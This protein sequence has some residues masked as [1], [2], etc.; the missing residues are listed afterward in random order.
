MVPELQSVADMK[1]TK[2][3]ILTT[4]LPIALTALG[5]CSSVGKSKSGDQIAAQGP[6]VLDARTNPGTF[7]LNSAY[8]PTQPAEILAEVK[9]FSSNIKDVRLRF[10]HVPLEIP[11]KHVEGSTW[12]AQ[13]SP[14]QLKSLAVGGQTMNYQVNVIARSADG[15]VATS[16]EPLKVAVSAPDLSQ[17]KG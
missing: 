8:Q 1:T 11:M 14:N 4:A 3:F 2:K 7:E 16:S 12:R 6:T 15:M 17:N 9:D 13:L 10:V 5:A